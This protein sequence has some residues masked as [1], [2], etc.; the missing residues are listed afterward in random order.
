MAVALFVLGYLSTLAVPSVL[1][2]L[3]LGGLQDLYSVS[4]LAGVCA[5][6][7]LANQVV[8]ASRPKPVL[9]LL[10]VKGLLQLHG[11]LA[12][13]ALATA[14]LHLSLKG[15]VGFGFSGVQPLLGILS[16]VFYLCAAL[17]AFILMSPAF[18]PLAGRLRAFRDY[19]FAHTP[20]SYVRS[21][22]IHGLTAP[23]LIVL[24]IH[25]LLASSASFAVNAAGS[26]FMIAWTLVS[27]VLYLRYRLRGRSVK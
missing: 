24:L 25:I 23:M 8:L 9:A 12:L 3:P 14:F 22:A 15:A 21:R 6:A 19:L 27:L 17:A 26:G 2:V 20:L 18:Y 13:C 10:G 11:V 16:L 1:F 7:M 5:W 4:V